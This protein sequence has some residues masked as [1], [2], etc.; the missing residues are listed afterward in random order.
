MIH[1]AR[2][3]RALYRRDFD[4]HFSVNGHLLREMWRM[5]KEIDIQADNE[6]WYHAKYISSTRS[7]EEYI[8]LKRVNK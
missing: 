6:K 2:V 1:N 4:K 5:N 8:L 7:R 3:P